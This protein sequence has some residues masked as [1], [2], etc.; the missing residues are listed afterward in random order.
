MKPNN[1]AIDVLN[2][3]IRI[4]NDRIEGYEKAIKD[5]AGDASLLSVFSGYAEQSRKYASELRR[6][7]SEQGGE[8]TEDSTT[9]GKIYRL[10]MDLRQAVSASESSSALDLCEYGEDAAQKA[11]KEALS[12]ESGLPADIVAV[13]TMQKAALRNAH[14]AIKQ[15][16]DE[17]HAAAHH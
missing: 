16:R 3:L 15:F 4:N 8:P 1:N 5:V 2:D 6:M 13:I 14:D 12:D 17:Q 9:S 11:Y 7:V 10:W